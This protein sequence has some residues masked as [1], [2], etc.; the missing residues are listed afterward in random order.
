VSHRFQVKLLA[1]SLRGA[2]AIKLAN[3][4]GEENREVAKTA[5]REFSGSR[6]MLWQR[7][8]P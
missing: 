8:N 3:S 4:G 5:R 6:K 1:E 7:G 2:A